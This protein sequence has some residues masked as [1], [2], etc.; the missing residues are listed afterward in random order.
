V[1][2]VTRVASANQRTSE[3]SG[4]EI[5]GRGNEE[6]LQMVEETDA[7]IGCCAAANAGSTPKKEVSSEPSQVTQGG[8]EGAK[9]ITPFSQLTQQHIQREKGASSSTEMS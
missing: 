3:Y 7:E 5:P 9:V 1:R 8:W 2:E 4:I 6:K